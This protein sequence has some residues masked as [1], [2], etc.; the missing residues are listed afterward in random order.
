[1]SSPL[2]LPKRLV[3]QLFQCRK[4][5]HGL[6]LFCHRLDVKICPQMNIHAHISTL[7]TI[8]SHKWINNYV[9]ARYSV[10]VCPR[11]HWR[12]GVDRSRDK[13][14]HVLIAWLMRQNGKLD[15]TKLKGK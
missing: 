7:L 12:V 13:Y 5:S 8:L 1:M 2:E 10:T 9:R 11:L 3:C 14:I 15:I 6:E 4:I